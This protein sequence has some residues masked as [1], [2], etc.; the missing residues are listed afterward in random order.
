MVWLDN[1]DSGDY[2]NNTG[3]SH[4]GLDHILLKEKEN[5]IIFWLDFNL[6]K[7]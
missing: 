2:H 4:T 3:S 7:K 1:G 5:K 6:I